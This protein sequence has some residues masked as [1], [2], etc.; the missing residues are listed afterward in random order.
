MKL[1]SHVLI[2]TMDYVLDWWKLTG[3]L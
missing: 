2:N 3:D 1:M